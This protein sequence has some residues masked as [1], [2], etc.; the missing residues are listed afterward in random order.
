MILRTEALTGVLQA[1]GKKE[2][3]PSK[4]ASHKYIVNMLAVDLLSLQ[5][6]ASEDQKTAI[7]SVVNQQQVGQE[8]R[9]A[10]EVFGPQN[11]WGVI[12]IEQLLTMC[13]IR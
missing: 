13:D 6:Y 9:L 1:I 8:L 12:G 4:F 5:N 10:I 3:E 2:F 7:C 11:P